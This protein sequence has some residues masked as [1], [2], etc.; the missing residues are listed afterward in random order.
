MVTLQAP[1]VRDPDCRII[2]DLL[3]GKTKGF[4]LTQRVYH[5]R[6]RISVSSTFGAGGGATAQGELLKKLA[7]AFKISETEIKVSGD[8]A[9]FA[10]SES[11][12]S[13]S[14]AIVPAG[15]SFEEVSRIANY[16]EG[17]RG[18]DLEIAVREAITEGNVGEFEKLKLKIE[19]LLGNDELKNN[20][21]WAEDVVGTTPV[22]KFSDVQ[23]EKLGTYGAAMEIVRP[24]THCRMGCCSTKDGVA[25]V[26]ERYTKDAELT[27]QNGHLRPAPNGTHWHVWLTKD[28]RG[29]DLLN[30]GL[31][32]DVLDEAILTVSKMNALH[33][34]DP[35]FKL[36]P[37]NILWTNNDYPSESHPGTK[38][39][40][41]CF[42]PAPRIQ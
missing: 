33:A 35:A 40:P 20:Q 30:G 3:S 2:G 41:Y 1:N 15:Y 16:L 18:A 17:K 29:H 4:V 23:F 32:L 24:E 42:W 9:L 5:G 14:L 27:D 8:E 36:P 13:M 11:P 38:P 25:R 19:E 7:S 39:T 6:T 21:R 31:W 26:M 22:E 12:N 10:V 34:D 37:F 28:Q